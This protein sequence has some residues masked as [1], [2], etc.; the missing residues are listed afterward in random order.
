MGRRK[1]ALEETEAS[2]EPVTRYYVAKDRY[3]NCRRG[4]VKPGEEVFEKDFPGGLETI[5]FHAK[6]GGIQKVE[7]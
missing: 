5:E 3:I 7:G 2:N 4:V 6:N 1:K